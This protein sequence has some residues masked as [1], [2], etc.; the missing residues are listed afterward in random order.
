M[1]SV[2]AD[3]WAPA[4]AHDGQVFRPHTPHSALHPSRGVVRSG[5]GHA[6]GE[7]LGMPGLGGWRQ[8]KS[9]SDNS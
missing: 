7:P 3:A 9:P 6:G 1:A 5:I 8:G 2:D 4:V